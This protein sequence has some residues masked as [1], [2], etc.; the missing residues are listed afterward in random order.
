MD[1]VHHNQHQQQ[2]REKQQIY[3]QLNQ[4]YC[5]ISFTV[6]IYSIMTIIH[7]LQNTPRGKNGHHAAKH[8]VME[9][10]RGFDLALHIVTM[11]NQVIY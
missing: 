10:E 5:L 8:V 11:L 1:G 7:V 9:T 3:R 6:P 4:V 2:K